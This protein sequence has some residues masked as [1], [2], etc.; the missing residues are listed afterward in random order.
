MNKALALIIVCETTSLAKTDN[1]YLSALIDAYYGLY[2][3]YGGASG[4]PAKRVFLHV[5]GKGNIISSSTTKAIERAKRQFYPKELFEIVPIICFDV[6]SKGKA[7]KAKNEALIRWCKKNG[8]LPMAFSK[9]IEQVLEVSHPEANKVDRAMYFKNTKKAYLKNERIK[10]KLSYST[11]ACLEG[12]NRANFALT[13]DK[14]VASMK[15][16]KARRA[17]EQ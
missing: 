1:V 4:Y 9:N 5:A 2:F 14:A 8:F 13:M 17:D 16:E 15:N 11:E 10:G 3:Q 7:E 6:D 12:Y